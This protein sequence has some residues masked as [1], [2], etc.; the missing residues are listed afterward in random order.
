MTYSEV[1]HI[2]EDTES[3]AAEL[4]AVQASS[5]GSRLASRKAMLV[6][7]AVAATA[8]AAITIGLYQQQLAAEG[9]ED[10][11]GVVSLADPNAPYH[12]IPRTGCENWKALQILPA[13]ENKSM[14]QCH[15]ECAMTPGCWSFNYQPGVCGTAESIRPQSCLLL[16]STFTPLNGSSATGQ[17]Y[18]RSCKQEVNNCWDL[19]Q[20]DE[21]VAGWIRTGVRT[22]CANWEQIQLG[23]TLNVKNANTCGHQCAHTSGCVSYNFQPGPCAGNEMTGEGACMLFNGQCTREDNTCWDLY[24]MNHFAKIDGTIVVETVGSD[25]QLQA[26]AK[27]AVAG[28]LGVNTSTITV[29]PPV[30]ARRLEAVTP[31]ARRL[32]SGCSS[33]G[34]NNLSTYYPCQCGTAGT[35]PTCTSLQL[36][37]V[38]AANVGTCIAATYL[39]RNVTWHYESDNA[40][41][42][43]DVFMKAAKWVKA[44]MA[45]ESALNK[46]LGALLAINGNAAHPTF[47]LTGT[48]TVK[49]ASLTDSVKSGSLVATAPTFEVEQQTTTAA[50]TTTTPAR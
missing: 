40:R 36:C 25:A 18:E 28:E 22:G 34:G 47:P 50:P 29:D 17:Q 35:P 3:S 37:S 41:E 13:I 24:E 14:E 6:V 2:V 27:T 1:Q 43:R 21:P 49:Q 45:L 10:S 8:S 11:G 20:M 32:L 5:Q 38:D 44:P 30:S 15:R 19:Y 4:D 33:T 31:E 46:A 9:T 23:K 39:K 42:A 48:P 26:A 16:G 12:K 7:S